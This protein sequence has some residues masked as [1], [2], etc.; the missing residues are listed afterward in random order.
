MPG[1]IFLMLSL[2]PLRIDKTTVQQIYNLSKIA[3]QKIFEVHE[4]K[5]EKEI[6]FLGKFIYI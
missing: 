4:N 3:K 6:L 5:F 1:D 2:R